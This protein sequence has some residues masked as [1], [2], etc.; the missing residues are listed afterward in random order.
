ME[1]KES[2]SDSQFLISGTGRKNRNARFL[3]LRKQHNSK[4]IVSRD[5]DWL[6][7]VLDAGRHHRR[8]SGLGVHLLR[9][10]RMRTS[11]VRTLEPLHARKSPHEPE[12]VGGG[13]SLHPRERQRREATPAPAVAPAG[14]CSKV[15]SLISI[16]LSMLQFAATIEHSVK[17][18]I[19]FQFAF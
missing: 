3:I 18:T 10:W 12:D 4:I 8:G 1:K 6:H 9:L 7:A 19:S 11:V 17:C 15:P 14:K 16:C 2:F 5:A 13:E